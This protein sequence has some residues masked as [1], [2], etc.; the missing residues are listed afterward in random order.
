MDLKRFSNQRPYAE[1]FVR[2]VELRYA[3]EPQTIHAIFDVF[4]RFAKKEGLSRE[5]R[6]ALHLFAP[7][8]LT[9]DFGSVLRSNSTINSK[10]S[11]TPAPT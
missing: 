7:G 4:K 1:A 10:R 6:Q 5:V 9:R 8:R 11:S 2:N 3:D